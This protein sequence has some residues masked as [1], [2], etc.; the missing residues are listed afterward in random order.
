MSGAAQGEGGFARMLVQAR[1][2]RGSALHGGCA[3]MC[4]GRARACQG[5]HTRV[6][7]CVRVGACTRVLGVM[8]THVGVMRVCVRAR[9]HVLGLCTHVRVGHTRVGD[10]TR[11][12]GG[13]AHTC[14]GHARALGITH[15]C[16]G[17]AHTSGGSMYTCWGVTHAQ[18]W[19]VTHA[20]GGAQA[21]PAA[22]WAQPPPG[23]GPPRPPRP[24]QAQGLAASGP[25]GGGRAGPA[26]QRPRASCLLPP[27]GERHGGA[28]VLGGGVMGATGCHGAG[29]CARG[30]Y[31]TL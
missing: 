18:A 14:Q 22:G 16:R 15:T 9:T 21:V 26:P 31:R 23:A 10:C 12:L 8:R 2:A 27:L 1:H 20:C 4:Q 29:G 28:R 5:L 3:H 7:S 30:C 25:P 24:P 11:V 19:E 17:C 6:G 13:H